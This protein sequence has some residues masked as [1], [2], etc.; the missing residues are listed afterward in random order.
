MASAGKVPANLYAGYIAFH[1]EQQFSTGLPPFGVIPLAPRARNPAKANCLCGVEVRGH[2][3]IFQAAKV[4]FREK[5][6]QQFRIDA[7][8]L[9]V[10]LGACDSVCV[11]DRQVR[12][13]HDVLL[14]LV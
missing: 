10:V 2:R 4:L 12:I 6:G 11:N 1:S 8:V 14:G 7:F 3:R 9:V 13:I 5:L